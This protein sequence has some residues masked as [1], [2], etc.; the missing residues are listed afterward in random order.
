MSVFHNNALIGSGAGTG[1]AAAAEYVIPKSLRFNK[2]DG[3]DLQKTFSS[4]GNRRT[5]T[6]SFWVKRSSAGSQR[7][8]FSGNTSGSFNNGWQITIENA[9][10]L[11]VN[12]ASPSF[13]LTTSRV[14]RDQSAWYHI[15][16]STDT[17]QSTASDRLKIYINGE[18]VTEFGTSTYPS[19]NDELNWNGAFVHQI[20][21]LGY[22]S[23]VDFDGYLADIQ[24]VD[25]QALAPTDFGETRSSDGVWVPKEYTGSY[26]PAVD[27]TQTWS[28]AAADAYGFDGSTTYNSAATRLYGTSTYHKIVDA[29]NPFTNVTS[30]VVG[31][32]ENVGNIKLDGTVYT[33]SYASGVGLTVTSPPS[34]FSDIEVLGA[35][36]GVQIAYV[37]IS[38][39]LLVDAG[40]TLSHN[41]FHLNFSDSSTIEALGFDSAP[42]TP[43]PDPKK[44]FDVVTYT[45]NGGAQNI[46]G[47]G[48]E[49]GLIWLKRRN[50]SAA[51]ALFDS[52]RGVTKVLESSNSGAEKTNDPALASFNP[53]GF[54]LNT[55]VG[56]I[57]AS[58][59]PYVAWM[60]RA[61]GP[62]VSN[63][64]GTITAQV[65]ASTD[66]GF[67]IVSFTGTGANA[68]VG[69]GLNAKPDF[70][71]V[72]RRS[73]TDDWECYHSA[74]GAT[75]YG[76][77]NATDAWT[78]SGG[79]S[80]WNDTE[81]TSS[82]FTVGTTDNVNGSGSTYVAYCW[83]EVSG[84]SK[85]SS[86]SGSGASGKAITG[87][88]FKPRWILIKNASASQNWFLY[89][90]ERGP[91]S[92]NN[93]VLRPNLSNAELQSSVNI[94][95]DADG[96]TLNS[97]DAAVNAS[98]NTYIY[99]AFADR[100]GNHWDVNNIVTN[101][102]LTT[103]KT[104]FD[105]VTYT[106]NGGTQKIGGPVYSDSLVASNG[107]F[108]S[109]AP[110]SGA[111]NGETGTADGDY[112]Q[113]SSGSNPNSLTFT[114]VGGIAYS[115][116]VEVYTIS[117]STTV[118]VNGGS[119][120]SV[121]ASQWV[122]VASGS[123][124]LTS[125]VVTRASTSGASLSG[126][127]IDGT[128]LLDGNGPGL[129]F[130]PDFVWIKP[131]SPNAQNHFL[132]DSVRGVGRSLRSSNNADE[133]GPNTGT[134]GD[135]RSFDANGFTL[136]SGAGGTGS[137]AVNNN[138]ESI[139]A[140]CWKAGGTAVSNTDGSIT[141]SVSANAAYGFSIVSFTATG[142]NGS[143]GH[144]LNTAP[145][146]II[147]K[148]RDSVDNWFIY[149][150]AIGANGYIMLNQTSAADTSN[151]TVWQNVSPT[152]SV[153]YA[154]T[155]GYNDSGDDVIAYCFANVPGYQ[156][157]GSW[158]GGGSTDVTVVTGFK[159]R[160]VLAKNSSGSFNWFIA[161]SERATS[162]PFDELVYAN[163]SEAETTSGS[164]DHIR[165][166]S[167][168]FTIEGNANTLNQSGSTFIYLAIGDD[169]IGSD[170][171]CLVDVPNAVT[172]DADATDTTGGYQRGNYAT[173][174]PL[175][176]GGSVSAPANGNLDFS[177]GSSYGSSLS[178]IAVS[179]G[180]WY[181]EFTKTDS[182]D[183][184]AVGVAEA[185]IDYST[186]FPRFAGG[187][188]YVDQGKKANSNSYPTYGE[189][190]TSG[191]VIGIAFDADAGSLSFYKNGV[192]QGEAYSGLTN[193]PYV[194]A[195][196][197]TNGTNSLSGTANFGQMRFKYPIPSGYAALNTTALPAA[198]IPDGSA[199]FDVK[200]WSGNSTARDITGYGFSPG[201]VWGKSRSHTN[202]H[203][204]MDI[205]RGAG[206]RLISN[207]TRAE[208]T[209]SG[210]LTSFNS[211]G[212]S[213]GTNDEANE[214]G[215]TYVGWAWN[216]GANSDKTYTVKVVSDSGNKYRFDDFGTSAVTLDLAEG[217][218]YVFD[219]SDSSNAGHPIRFG[220]SANGTDYT[221]GV[222]HTG[223][224]GSAG[225]KTTLVLGTGVSTLYYSC[226]NH[227]GM[228]GQINTNST[229]GASNFDGTIQATVK[230]NPEAGFS[231][232]KWTGSNTNGYTVGHGLNA[233]PDFMIF[234]NTDAAFNW[235]VYHSALGAT[236]VLRLNLT[237]AELD[238]AGFL[239]DTEPTSSVFTT[240]SF[241]VWDSDKDTVG[242][243][244]SAVAGY[245]AIGSYEGNGSTDGPF[246]HLGF[247]PALVILKLV[248]G[249]ASN[250]KIYDSTRDPDNPIEKQLYPSASNAEP[251]DD[252]RCDFLSNGFKVRTAGSEDNY[253]NN[254]VIYIA[255]ASNPFQANGGLAR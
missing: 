231:I 48:F 66:Y 208:D 236:K 132:Y 221:T 61:G 166:N 212:F 137:G 89:D 34:S 40:V 21:G 90:T 31:T 16:V 59:A 184:L 114:P 109:V 201:W 251:S 250:W 58:S 80:R 93:D 216:A 143:I 108:D 249:V 230:A 62:A 233:K 218:T 210:V 199:H 25:G 240:G 217:S 88:G 168:G 68:T 42:T 167:D 126:I 54:S 52:I 91:D 232:C 149:H 204:L 128:V 106:G 234:K 101:E 241:G 38:G 165:F 13:N 154:S 172:A 170:E 152:D 115:T 14:L 122:S 8:I 239:N 74:L 124:T 127:R 69:H 15:V 65:S 238:D 32:S 195:V 86:Y 46:G 183:G 177:S 28:S 147:A 144:G 191:D 213:L 202:S 19:Q 75:Y 11:S 142:A 105:V 203:W 113:A 214:S 223:T 35:S 174:N 64:D 100:P 194:M 17:T 181:W 134:D 43:D 125:L 2:A 254:T 227:S 161:D 53:D 6:H 245:S 67:S 39:V 84:Y 215:R 83:S 24:F 248:E 205:V 190:W 162:N 129:S 102:G 26:G 97:S 156:R 196:G 150:S 175:A 146:F 123:G 169:E 237:N 135:L 158:V 33:T 200:L 81:P 120:Q 121:S 176:T 188:A 226:L 186:D 27:Q 224:P 23:S 159:P 197:D 139:V 36:N 185:S 118:S 130:K 246:V 117:S 47:L 96:F 55:S 50:A 73:A 252:A 95:F 235:H 198:T 22:T 193:G 37:K 45:G 82:L 192:S 18:Q 10:T 85:F 173:L 72:K 140:W 209:P 112:A 255:F 60:W 76:K 178:T 98:G 207:D 160:F 253:N 247:K 211:D 41:G 104:Q 163:T 180:K 30:V 153:F 242:Y 229:G 78:T 155:G 4:A 12:G 1:A 63:S 56:Q 77:L 148:N 171:D 220:T 145:A 20:G 228:G 49:P 9:D 87:L 5:F 111:F 51:H 70:Y 3:A 110:A 103:S 206:N 164:G 71:V 79:T 7:T 157:I 136:G 29:D 133:K 151:S 244:F 99:A 225:A 131:Y 138:N 187:A 107:S 92:T 141:S 57:N 44:G 189:T 222:T 243:I 119:A 182:S 219:Q 116:G 94:D 179:T